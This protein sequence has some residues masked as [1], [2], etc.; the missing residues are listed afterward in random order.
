MATAARR[1]ALR[2][3]TRLTGPAGLSDFLAGPEASALPPR[4]RAFL[5]ELVLGVLRRRGALDHA[6]APLLDHPLEKLDSAVHNTLRLGAYQILHLR[7]PHRAAVSEAVE[8]AREARVPRA[9]GL[10][11]AVLRRLAREG[12][13]RTADPERDPLAWLTSEGSLP[14]WLA[15]RWLG[16]LGAARTVARAR[17]LLTPPPAT[18][19]LNPRVPNASARVEDAGLVP[20][21]LAVPGAFCATAGHAAPLAAEGV[22]YLQD[23][24]SQLVGH[25]AALDRPTRVLDACAAPG[26]KATLVA[27]LVA[28]TGHVVAAEASASRLRTL[29]RL[30]ARWDARNVH[31][32]A[33][34]ARRPP[35]VGSSFDSVLLDAPCSGL[36]TLRRN[37][38]IKW[39]L[40][41]EDI[42][43]HAKRQRELLES[44]APL[45]RGPGSLVYAT[46]SLEPEES[47]GVL[48][49]FLEDH[50]EFQP[51]PLPA[52]AQPFCEGPFVR[53]T[54]ETHGIDG[55]AAAVLRRA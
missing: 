5:Q 17:V 30:V 50:P 39:R 26:G 33:A 4:E 37:P 11:N 49:G 45:V 48:G 19:R 8:L 35:F 40:R 16:R 24:A 34:D 41:A 21:P 3:L 46:C 20:Q 55:F 38:D 23:E 53:I 6:L 9:A 44:L 47:D 32:V 51:A 1:L 54:P 36:G 31:V 13:G 29:A 2:V 14:P 52:W 18:F 42:T 22:L 10:V 12:P 27:D 43:R 25:L 15:V 7:V 28:G